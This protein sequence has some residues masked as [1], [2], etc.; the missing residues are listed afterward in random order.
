MRRARRVRRRGGGREA[1]WERSEERK[2]RDEGGGEVVVD[3]GRVWD[4]GCGRGC[5]GRGAEDVGER[6]LTRLKLK[7]RVG[8]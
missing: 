6:G 4:W 7:R 8:F 2:D 5:R 3:L 1:S